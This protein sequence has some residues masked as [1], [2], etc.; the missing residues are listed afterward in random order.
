MRSADKSRVPRRRH[1]RED[2]SISHWC[3]IRTYA[4][5]IIWILVS[6]NVKTASYWHTYMQALNVLKNECYGSDG[7]VKRDK[8]LTLA[9]FR[10][11]R[12]RIWSSIV[13][14]DEFLFM[15]IYMTLRERT[16]T[17]NT[18]AIDC[19]TSGL[20]LMIIRFRMRN[21]W[22]I[23]PV[24]CKCELTIKQLSTYH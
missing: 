22:E 12:I 6:C 10:E 19:D 18:L 17:K 14:E 24:C 21:Y 11:D 7:Y 16:L 4:Q 15:C 1:N 3:S 2:G 13:H 20:I 5:A 23:W 8:R 9:C